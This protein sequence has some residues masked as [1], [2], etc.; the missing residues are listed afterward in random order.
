MAQEYKNEITP[1]FTNIFKW[2]KNTIRTL[3]NSLFIVKLRQ[4]SGKNR[5]GMAVKAKGLK[6]STLA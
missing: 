6:A 5:Q 2:P 4:G 3:K 1:I